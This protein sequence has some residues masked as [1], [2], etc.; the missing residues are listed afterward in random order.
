M[1]GLALLLLMLAASVCS[2]AVAETVTALESNY[3]DVK[4]TENYRGFCLDRELTG[5]YENDIFSVAENTSAARDNMPEQNDISQKLKLLFAHCF[6]ELFVSDGNGGYMIPD[7]IADGH[8]GNAVYHFAGDQDY[9]YSLGKTLVD[10]VNAYDGPE[11]PDEGYTKT[12]DNGDIVKFSFKVFEPRK[13]GQQTFF[14]YRINTASVADSENGTVTIERNS[15]SEEGVEIKVKVEPANGY[16]LEKLI[17]GGEDVSGSVQDN[18]Y[19]FMLLDEDVTVQATFKK[20]AEAPT[21]Y[22][23]TVNTDGNG[24]ATANP[25]EGTTGTEVTLSATPNTGYQFKEWQVV[26]GGVTIENNAF[27]IGNENVEVKAI[28]EAIPEAPATYTVTF[29]A[30]GGSGTMEIQTFQQGVEQ[31][32]TM[33]AFTYAGHVFDGWNI[34]PDGSGDALADGETLQLAGNITLYAQWKAETVVNPLRIVKHP[35]DQYVTAGQQAEFSVEAEGDGVTYQW[36]IDRVDGNGLC[37][38]DGANEKTYV[39]STVNPDNDEYLYLCRVTDAHGNTML[40]GAAVLH[41]SALSAMP[42]TGDASA[43]LL[44]LAMGML[45]M[46]GMALLGRKAKAE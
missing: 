23:V 41:V 12:L 25:T 13:E 18:E 34:M 35:E 45:S 24:T 9:V 33:N 3:L 19:A 37:V 30:N 39:T 38:I 36:Y 44:W 20:S 46:L 14:A 42:A 21:T 28:F 4:F 27:A 16:E 10:K 17:V 26:S 6:D 15:G 2:G 1:V 32:L 40:S 29:D 7:D 5:A 31:A 43:P 22:T 11:I 8:L